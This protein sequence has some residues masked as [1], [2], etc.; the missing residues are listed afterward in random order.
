[1]PAKLGNFKLGKHVEH[2][3]INTVLEQM[4]YD[5][6]ERL[7]EEWNAKKGN[8]AGIH[9]S[10]IIGSD[11]GFCLRQII[12][13]Q[14]FRHAPLPLHGRTLRIFRHGWA[15]HEK[16]QQLF[17]DA[18]IAEEVET[19]HYHKE[20][21]ASFTPDIIATIA[22]RRFII[23]IKSM[24]DAS[25]RSM[26]SIHKSAKIQANMYM[27]LEGVKL[28][29]VL[30]E[31]KDTQEFRVWVIEYDE[32][33]V[34][35]YVR[36]LAAIKE[37]LAAYEADRTLPKRHVLCSMETTSKAKNCPVREACFA[38]KFERERMRKAYAKETAS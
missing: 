33:V 4:V 25:Y 23:E 8:R 34:R 16:W 14:F 21:G 38:G 26:K 20:T 32:S 15:V 36:R 9:V 11:E 22:R 35:K 7:F 13:M 5:R 12:L 6:F 31:N 10:S 37:N 29:I 19:T 30:V 1:M 28:A 3:K 2:P 17:V 24:N 27:Y 18:G